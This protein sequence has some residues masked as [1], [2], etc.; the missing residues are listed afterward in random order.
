MLV[1]RGATVAVRSTPTA[2]LGALLGI[3]TLQ[4]RVSVQAAKANY[5]IKNPLKVKL[6]KGNGP[7][8]LTSEDILGMPSDRTSQI[9]LSDENYKISFP[10]REDIWHIVGFKKGELTGRNCIGAVEVS[11]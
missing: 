11:A 2:A 4:S 1:L 6:A 10:S 5:R 9:C 3:E 8:E 7:M